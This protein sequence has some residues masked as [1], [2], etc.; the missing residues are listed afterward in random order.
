MPP[1][2]TLRVNGLRIRELRRAKAWNLGD[3]ARRVGIHVSHLSRIETDK[4]PCPS[5]KVAIRIARELGVATDE[6]AA[7]QDKEDA[8]SP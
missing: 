8:W 1:T 2:N 3:L 4:R 6:I 7:N 5:E